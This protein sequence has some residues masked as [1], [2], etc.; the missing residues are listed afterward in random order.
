MSTLF[1]L[2]QGE[3]GICFAGP[4]VGAP[5]GVMILESLIAKGAEKIIV[6]GWCGSLTQEISIGDIRNLGITMV[7][8]HYRNI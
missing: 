2:E 4:Y 7:R 1:T 3:K 8:R 5:Y 6:L